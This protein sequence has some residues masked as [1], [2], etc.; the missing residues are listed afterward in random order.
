MDIV[1]SNAR[2]G[3]TIRLTG[4]LV[5]RWVLVVWGL[6]FL[7]LAAAIPTVMDQSLAPA[8]VAGILGLAPLLVAALVLPRTPWSLA[9]ND[10]GISGKMC[11]PRPYA[12]RWDE[13]VKARFTR[14]GGLF[15]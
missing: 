10:Q 3:T 6:V 9:W 1:S 7:A 11:W 2:K 5:L 15:S 14:P 8:A 13:I 12:V 4:T